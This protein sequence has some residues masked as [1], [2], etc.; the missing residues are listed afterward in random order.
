[1]Q[2]K[3]D[4]GGEHSSCISDQNFSARKRYLIKTNTQ[5]NK[6]VGGEHSSCI[7][8]STSRPESDT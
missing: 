7:S 5:A 1:M 3:K 2:A 4:V 6:D 8:D